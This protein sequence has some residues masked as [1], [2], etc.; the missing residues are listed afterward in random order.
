MTSPWQRQRPQQLQKTREDNLRD[1]PEQD[2][3]GLNFQEN[4]YLSKR[5][6][7]W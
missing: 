7:R 1:Y 5:P 6:Q 4:S 3:A 2:S